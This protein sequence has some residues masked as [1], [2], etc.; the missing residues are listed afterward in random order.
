MRLAVPSI[1]E[2]RVVGQRAQQ[3]LQLARGDRR[4]LR[5]LAR[6][7]RMRGDLH[8]EIGRRDVEPPVAVL[9]QDIRKDRQRMPPFDD[10][11]DRL[12]RFQQR[13]AWDLF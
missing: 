7:I 4:R 9:E 2:Q 6:K 10:A 12:Q 11:R 3:I 8:F 5:F 13:V 1:G